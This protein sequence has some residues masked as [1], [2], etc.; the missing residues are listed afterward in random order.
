MLICVV[1]LVIAI[2]IWRPKSFGRY[3]VR[4]LRPK[5]KA[6]GAPIPV[7]P[8][9]GIMDNPEELGQ[10][11]VAEGAVAYESQAVRFELENFSVRTLYDKLEDQ[12]LHVSSQ[13]A[14]HQQDLRGFYDRI[15][16]QAEKLKE[17]LNN[18]NVSA[19][20]K[21]INCFAH[22]QLFL[23]GKGFF[24][25]RERSEAFSRRTSFQK[26]F[27]NSKKRFL[28]L[29]ILIKRICSYRYAAYKTEVPILLQKQTFGNIFTREVKQN[30]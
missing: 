13:L 11:G 3:P 12:T 19:L 27:N 7:L 9:P 25:V 2:V 26:L 15:S 4:A 30:K 18:M 23:K 28:I 20:I 14:R 24:G 17:M 8:I 29:A 22:C 16:Q 1:M 5:Y 21:V 10:R 6:L